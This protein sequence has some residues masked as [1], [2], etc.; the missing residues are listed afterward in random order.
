MPMHVPSNSTDT[1]RYTPLS[2]V[3][4]I[5]SEYLP[6]FWGKVDV[7]AA[8]ALALAANILVVETLLVLGY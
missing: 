5:L 2:L 8:D 6:V 4:Y 1:P 7:L 3:K